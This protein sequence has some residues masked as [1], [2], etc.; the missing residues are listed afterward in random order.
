MTTATI[1]LFGNLEPNLS[2]ATFSALDMISR[3]QQNKPTEII[4][5]IHSWG[6][7]LGTALALY[8]LFASSPIPITTHNIGEVTSAANIVFLAGSKRFACRRSYFRH[9]GIFWNTGASGNMHK[10]MYEDIVRTADSVENIMADIMAERTHWTAAQAKSHFRDPLLLTP[11][12]ALK[13]GIIHEIK[14]IA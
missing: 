7:D 13:S 6:G 1:N 11:D 8:N 10:V 2:T 3:N 14:E 4:V 9:H 12:E 5:L